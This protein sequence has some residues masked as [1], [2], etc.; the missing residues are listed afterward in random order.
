MECVSH[1][2]EIENTYDSVSNLS[3]QEKKDSSFDENRINNFLDSILTFKELLSQKTEKINSIILRIEKITWY[4]DVDE[5]GLKTI[6]DIIAL[7]RDWHYALVRHYVAMNTLRK[8]GIAKQE[9]KTF[10]LA[11]DDLKEIYTD[12]EF[13]F[14][15]VPNMA[16]F[17]EITKQLSIV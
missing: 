12:L 9:I 11:V 3:F 2:R 13:V 6:N 5:E 17:N 8:K 14:F 15:Q 4:N 16:S 7:A 1:K 10:K